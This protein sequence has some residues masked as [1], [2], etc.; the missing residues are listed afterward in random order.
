MRQKNKIPEELTH[1]HNVPASLT[2][3][4]GC[5]RLPECVSPRCAGIAVPQVWPV[6]QWRMQLVLGVVTQTLST[7]SRKR[8]LGGMALA[9]FIGC[10]NWF[11]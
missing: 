1:T 5:V 2:H 9:Q 4:F 3:S 6:C 8:D 11:G 7:F 10:G